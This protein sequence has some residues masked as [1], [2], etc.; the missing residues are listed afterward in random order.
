MISGFEIKGLSGLDDLLEKIVDGIKENAYTKKPVGTVNED[1]RK[2]FQSLNKFRDDLEYELEI[3]KKI[4]ESEM[5]LVL[6]KEFGDR[7]EEH[8]E[9]KSQLWEEVEDALEIPHDGNYTI[10]G[11]TGVV[12]EKIKKTGGPNPEELAEQFMKKLK[13]KKRL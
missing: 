12:S 13:E 10:S 2:R 5:Q 1:L 3:R 4:M 9:M 6:Y 8:S 7:M 11:K